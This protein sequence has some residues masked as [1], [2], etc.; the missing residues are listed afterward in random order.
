LHLRLT[1]MA[2]TALG[3]IVAS[4]LLASTASA[5]C[6]APTSTPFQPWNDLNDYALAPGGDFEAPAAWTLQGGAALVHGG[7]PF[8]AT[9]EV[10]D[11]VLSLPNGSSAI[12]PPVCLTEQH[13]TFR[14]FAKVPQGDAGWLR[15]EA[16]AT[17]P[18]EVIGLGGVNGSTSWAPM[19][20]LSTGARNLQMGA[21]GSVTVRFRLTADYGAWQI[22]DVFVDPQKWG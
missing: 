12:S 19:P 1:R 10:G 6:E 16:L 3:G 2:R 5:A 20:S 8:A 11:R 22:D 9:G 13:P 18:T 4:L 14:F 7:E 15:A 21:D 17:D